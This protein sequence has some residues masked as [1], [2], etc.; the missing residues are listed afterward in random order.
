MAHL[1]QLSQSDGSTC[2]RQ[3][4]GSA[5]PHPHLPQPFTLADPGG[6]LLPQG[7][8]LQHASGWPCCMLHGSETPTLHHVPASDIAGCTIC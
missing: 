3:H 7:V 1:G 2:V 5:S 8:L 6:H 4:P